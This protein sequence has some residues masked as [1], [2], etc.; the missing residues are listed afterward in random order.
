[1][2]GSLRRRQRFV[3]RL[4]RLGRGVAASAVVAASLAGVAVVAPGAAG[5]QTPPPAE[6]TPQGDDAS[7]LLSLAGCL[8]GSRH[9]AIT[10]VFDDSR[11]LAETDPDGLRVTAALAALDGLTELATGPEETRTRV[12]LEVASFSDRY[13]V[14]LPWT[15]LDADTA[16]DIRASATSFE[17]RVGGIETDIVNA[18]IGAR[19]SL[20]SRSA[21]VEAE[22]GAAPC[23]AVV[24]FTDGD[25][26]VNARTP[27]QAATAG[28][29]KPYAPG[30]DL[31]TKAGAAAAVDAGRTAMCRPDG[32]ADGLRGDGIVLL[33]VMLRP[34]D[35]ADG[36]SFLSSITTGEGPDGPCGRIAAGGSGQY[37]RASDTDALIVGFDEI[38]ARVAGG[39]PLPPE[40][41]VVCGDEDC[42]EGT[43]TF[44]VDSLTRRVRAIALGP[45]AGVRLRLTGPTGSAVITEAGE[46]EVGDL[47]AT[48][49]PVADRGFTVSVD[50]PAETTGWVGTWTLSIEGDGDLVGKPAT[51]QVYLFSDVQARMAPGG[52]ERGAESEVTAEL[53]LPEG[54][55][56]DGLLRSVEAKALIEDPVSGRR[57]TVVLAGPVEGP[58]VGTFTTPADTTANAFQVTAELTVESVDGSITATRS[59]RTTALVRRPDGSVQFAPAVLT[60][61]A[62]EGTGSSDADL[63][64]VGGSGEG[65]V[66]LDEATFDGGRG[67]SVTLDGQERVDE[68]SCLRVPAG[69][70]L[71]VSVEVHASERL[72]AT[73]RGI[74]RLREETAGQK[75]TVTDLQLSTSLTRGVDEAQ[76]NVLAALL[77]VGGL[78][79]PLVLLLAINAVTARFQALDAVRGAAIPVRVVRGV[80]QRTD[81]APRRLRFSDRDFESLANT[82]NVRRFSF[83]GVAFRARASRNPFGVTWAS[84][85]PEGGAEKLKG[86]VGRR[87]ELDTTLAGS[88]VYLLDP[89]RTRADRLGTSEGTVLA[90]IAEGPTGVQFDRLLKDLEGRIGRVAADLETA[91]RSQPAAARPAGKR[92]ADPAGAP[93]SERPSEPSTASSDDATGDPSAD[94]PDVPSDDPSAEA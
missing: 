63:V 80:V 85:A 92:S 50:R 2:T 47:T 19:S 64:I 16:A 38:A 93:S 28:T 14:A 56:S 59:P 78:L 73:V 87:V 5:A 54:V 48:V 86:G 90:F 20:S 24:L 31:S 22:V 88:W 49:T 8:Q 57:S 45:E 94:R 11:S 43:R 35:A 6:P 9:L 26:V 18:L 69:E 27:E 60:L 34:D 70:T 52:F 75:A 15:T 10:F 39:T 17:K 32:I 83:G 53:V 23:K 62:I 71:T 3:A 89:D 51:V 72:D 66:W 30:V 44:E 68:A 33:S 82:G 67:L 41:M 81:G 79:L 25:Y 4:A 1:M 42:A 61:P 74:L 21:D 7:G 12:D 84:A 29:T 36:D 91:V 58:Y 76:R 65:C 13:R 46:I 77:L 40:A 37:L 55:S